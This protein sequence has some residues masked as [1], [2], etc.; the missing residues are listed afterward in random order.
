[1]WAISSTK[2]VHVLGDIVC[3]L[4]N[5][6]MVDPTPMHP[7]TNRECTITGDGSRVVPAVQKTTINVYFRQT[8]ALLHL[9]YVA[10]TPLLACTVRMRAA[11]ALSVYLTI[12][13]VS[14]L[15]CESTTTTCIIELMEVV[16]KEFRP[17]L[18]RAPPAWVLPPHDFAEHHS[19][20][21]SSDRL[22]RSCS[23]KQQ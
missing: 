6:Y 1:M 9:D 23:S 7:A 10:V 21:E 22:S 16:L 19:L 2:I 13:S 11:G 3:R 18:F 8:I 5:T 4:G 12:R 17:T 14:L 20:R 15:P